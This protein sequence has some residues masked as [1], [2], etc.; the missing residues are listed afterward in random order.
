MVAKLG[1]AHT[2]G[3]NFFIPAAVEVLRIFNCDEVLEKFKKIPLSNNTIKRRID[4]MASNVESKLIKVVN[5]S[6]MFALQC[7]ET[8]DCNNMSYLIVFVRYLNENSINEDMLFCETLQTTTTG[9]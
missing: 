1:L 4:Y 6:S 8:T 5:K 2:I 9:V 3:E 7:D